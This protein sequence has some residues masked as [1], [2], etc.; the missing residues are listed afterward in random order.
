MGDD[1]YIWAG[2]VQAITRSARDVTGIPFGASLVNSETWAT[3]CKEAGSEAKLLAALKV[4]DER[5]VK[6]PIIV[7]K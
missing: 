6:A 4:T 7:D 1:L 5:V 3:M 2:K